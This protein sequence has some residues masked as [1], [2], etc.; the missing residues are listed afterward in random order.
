M[1]NASTLAAELLGPAGEAWRSPGRGRVRVAVSRRVPDSTRRLPV[2]MLT[3]ESA[4]TLLR[5][6]L[7]SST[8]RPRSAPRHTKTSMSGLSPEVGLTED[9]QLHF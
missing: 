9:Q 4:S 1:S 8:A 2:M 3:S 7:E 5:C 6:T